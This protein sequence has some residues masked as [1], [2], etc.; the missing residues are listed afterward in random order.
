MTRTQHAWT[1]EE[2]KLLGKMTDKDAAAKI[3]VTFMAVYQKR[4]ALGIACH[5]KSTAS[6]DSPARP[7]ARRSERAVA[8]LTKAEMTALEA[9]CKKAGK[10]PGE[11]ARALLVALV[12]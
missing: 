4:K 12:S 5:G 8:L 3:G 7:E 9:L 6:A 2:I 10:T 11:M 1:D